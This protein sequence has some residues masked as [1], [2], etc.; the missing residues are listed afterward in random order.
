MGIKPPGNEGS[1]DKFLEMG[2]ENLSNELLSEIFRYL[3][4]FSICSIACTNRRFRAII[5]DNDDLL[6]QRIAVYFLHKI[7]FNNFTVYTADYQAS[8]IEEATPEN[9]W[10]EVLNANPLFLAPDGREMTEKM[11]KIEASLNAGLPVTERLYAE[12]ST[13]IQ[14][15]LGQLKHNFLGEVF[16]SRLDNLSSSLVALLNPNLP[17]KAQFIIKSLFKIDLIKKYNVQDIDL[18]LQVVNFL[19]H[20]AAERLLEHT[21]LCPSIQNLEDVLEV[22]FKRGLYSKF[23]KKQMLD[24]S[25]QNDSF[26]HLYKTAAYWH[27]DKQDPESRLLILA[28]YFATILDK[29]IESCIDASY[30]YTVWRI[31]IK[32]DLHYFR[33]ISKDEVTWGIICRWFFSGMSMR[34]LEALL[35]AQSLSISTSVHIQL[36]ELF[37]QRGRRIEAIA[38]LELFYFAL[39][40]MANM[41]KQ[42]ECR[43]EELKPLALF[44]HDEF[45]WICYWLTRYYALLSALM[46]VSFDEDLI[47]YYINFIRIAKTARKREDAPLSILFNQ[48]VVDITEQKG[49][50]IDIPF[51]VESAQEIAT[52]LNNHKDRR[53]QAETLK[54]IIKYFFSLREV[55]RALSL[56]PGPCMNELLPLLVNEDSVDL[57]AKKSLLIAAI[58][59]IRH[60]KYGNDDDTSFRDIE[61]I[62]NSQMELGFFADVIESLTLLAKKASFES[63]YYEVCLNV[64]V[65]MSQLNPGVRDTKLLEKLAETPKSNKAYQDSLRIKKSRRQ[66]VL[67]SI[68]LIECSSCEVGG[69][70]FLKDLFGETIYK[71]ILIL[72]NLKRFNDADQVI[73][74]LSPPA[75]KIKAQITAAK[76][77]QR[78]TLA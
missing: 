17:Q 45:P 34:S 1:N 8:I 31:E 57:A 76:H 62:I 26:E 42:K 13:Q 41:L 22:A 14:S 43:D 60:D 67:L 16:A 32:G 20:D 51:G 68:S 56:I 46:R 18:L 5:F 72:L 77:K 38:Q 74:T 49:F 15:E 6:A 27:L 70:E 53:W 3:P 39:E 7:F 9:K 35:K 78:L 73:K 65:K 59:D 58:E 63:E 21:M 64:L 71:F 61:G 11:G 52:L 44:S 37:L 24:F 40:K 75:F 50:W 25:V 47:Y 48:I 36:A 19:D 55:K 23:I 2:L 54:K 66:L 30:F 28:N 69:L 33:L 4:T 10:I 12:D 29:E